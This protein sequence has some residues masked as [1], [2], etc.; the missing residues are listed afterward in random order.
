MKNWF[1]NSHQ[2]SPLAHAQVAAART[3]LVCGLLGVVVGAWSL[4]PFPEAGLNLHAVASPPPP[5]PLAPSAETV[6]QFN[7]AAF[8]A[9]AFVFASEP[10]QAKALAPIEPPPPPVLKLQ[11]LAVAA[12]DAGEGFLASLYNPEDDKVRSAGVGETVGGWHI[13]G[14]TMQGVRFR[15]G[16][17][18][19]ALVLRSDRPGKDGGAP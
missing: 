1:R 7:L 8:D 3:T 5:P 6:G 15:Q 11:L 12:G 18:T 17:T 14:A 10:E 19:Q 13:E 9:A 2:T 16:A 4:W